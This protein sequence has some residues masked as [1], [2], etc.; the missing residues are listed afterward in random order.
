MALT[1]RS[2][3]QPLSSQDSHIAGLRKVGSNWPERINQKGDSSVHIRSQAVCCKDF[4][5]HQRTHLLSLSH[6]HS[7]PSLAFF[8]LASFSGRLSPRSSKDATTARSRSYQV[9]SPVEKQVLSRSVSVGLV[10]GLWPGSGT[11]PALNQSWGLG[12][13][14]FAFQGK[15]RGARKGQISDRQTR[16]W[17]EKG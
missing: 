11:F 10:L 15:D 6:S 13:W 9:R 2:H 16:C 14:S 7:L 8:L 1:V 4:K 17:Y 12:V 5:Q 3:R